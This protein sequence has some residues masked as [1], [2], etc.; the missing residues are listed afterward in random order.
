M[1]APKLTLV[2]IEVKRACNMC[3]EFPDQPFRLPYSRLQTFD[4][5]VLDPQMNLEQVDFPSQGPILCAEIYRFCESHRPQ[6]CL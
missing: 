4:F 5:I 1:L 6:V 2:L 3:P